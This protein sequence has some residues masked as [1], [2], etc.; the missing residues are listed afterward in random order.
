MF[1]VLTGIVALQVQPL[2]AVGYGLIAL[3][4]VD[5]ALNILN[6]SSLILVHRRVSG[7]C[8][9]DVVVRRFAKSKASDDLGLAVD[10]FLSFTLVAIVI[11]GGLLPRLPRWAVHIWDVAVVFNVLGAGAGRLLA[12]LRR[13]EAGNE[14]AS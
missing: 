12:A 13:R 3:G 1:K 9:A 4:F 7:V 10:V 14:R 5:A 2:V 8:V 11:G 6:L